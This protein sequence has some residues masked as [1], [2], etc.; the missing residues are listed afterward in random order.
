VF[1]PL[2]RPKSRWEFHS[3][4]SKVQN[5]EKGGPNTENIVQLASAR[6]NFPAIYAGNPLSVYAVKSAKKS[7]AFHS[8]GSKMQ[9]C[10]KAAPNA[11]N[12]VQLASAGIIIISLQFMLETLPMFTPLIR[13]KRRGVFHSCG[14]KM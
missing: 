6:V 11:E 5:C 9:I 12:I 14:S 7:G 3:C 2:I 1:T 8:C 4:G 13:P 10:E